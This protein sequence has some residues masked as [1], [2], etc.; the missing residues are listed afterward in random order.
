MSRNRFIIVT[1][2]HWKSEPI[3]MLKQKLF[4]CSPLPSSSTL[5][6]PGEHEQ[7]AQPYDS[8]IFE[9]A[10][11]SV[12]VSYVV[13][14]YTNFIWLIDFLKV[15]YNE[16]ILWILFFDS[17][18]QEKAILLWTRSNFQFRTAYLTCRDWK[19]DSR[20]IYLLTNYDP[21]DGANIQSDV[22]LQKL[23]A[24]NQINSVQN[25]RFWFIWFV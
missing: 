4:P 8:T 15:S 13:Q 5:S 19:R 22:S 23:V 6:I 2:Y 10:L 1:V 24:Q 18:F 16:K 21:A 9:Y 12:G 3:F 20:Y 11:I 17:A 7:P 25:T 14:L